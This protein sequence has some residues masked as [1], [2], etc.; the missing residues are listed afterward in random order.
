[1]R[2]GSAIRPKRTACAR[3][4]VVGVC[5][6]DRD[7]SVHQISVVITTNNEHASASCS[8]LIGCREQ[9][10]AVEHSTSNLQTI[11]R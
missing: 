7:Q 11:Q 9:H 1:M 10:S 2:F 6:H 4:T 3:G 5:D 8:R